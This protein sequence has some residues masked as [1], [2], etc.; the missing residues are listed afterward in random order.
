MGL[1]SG[2]TMIVGVIIGSGIFAAPGPLFVEAGS[3]G[4]TL[5]IWLAAGILSMTGAF[6]YAELGTMITKSGGEYQYLKAAYGPL[7]GLMFSWANLVMANAIGTAAIAVVF[8]EYLCNIIYFD[9]HGD[10]DKTPKAPGYLVKVVACLAIGTVVVLNSLTRKGGNIVS[11]VFTSFK[12]I[13]IIVIVGIGFVWIGKGE[14]TNFQ[15]PF[16]GSKSDI[17]SYGTAASL[18]LFAFNGWNN[19]NF[20]TGELKN[21]QRNLPLAIAIS[22]VVVMACYE[23]ANVAYFAVLPLETIRTSE[24]VAMQLGLKAMGTFGG[25]F[26]AVM[27]CCSAFGAVNAN[28]WAASRLTVTCAEE[29]IL[30]PKWLSHMHSTR[31]TPIRALLF[32][33]VLSCLWTLPGN[34]TY[35]AKIY[36]FILWIFYFLT[37]LAVIVLRFK[38]P[39]APRPFRVWIPCAYIFSIVALYLV[40]SPLFATKGFPWLYLGCV[41]GI[42]LATPIWYFRVRRPLSQGKEVNI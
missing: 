16:E 29:G 42:G 26:M 31:Q 30:F 28:V 14:T 5:L 18:A 36:A 35:L 32:V 20:A 33:F 39:A 34:F 12:I 41:I 15:K 4:T 23:L 37:V 25:Y 3:V 10:P 8:G 11:N 6:C 7:L 13:A 38:D 9:P 21:P 27:V 40:I 17:T 19:L 24:T 1:F 22:C 2:V